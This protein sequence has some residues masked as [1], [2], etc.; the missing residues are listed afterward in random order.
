VYAMIH[1]F[2]PIYLNIL[3]HS[4]RWKVLSSHAL[5]WVLS[6]HKE[7]QKL[8]VDSRLGLSAS[9][10]G[11]KGGYYYDYFEIR[12]SNLMY[13]WTEIIWNDPN[14]DSGDDD[15]AIIV[16]FFALLSI[17]II[18]TITNP[19]IILFSSSVSVNKNNPIACL[20]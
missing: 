9:S 6:Q 8:A 5:L 13:Y 10:D 15:V 1:S 2:L 12:I 11:A 16:P 14:G 4:I 20:N 3:S 18:T 19:F 7:E 17:I